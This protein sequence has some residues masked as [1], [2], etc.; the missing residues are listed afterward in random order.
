MSMKVTMAEFVGLEPCPFCGGE[1]EVIRN[2]IGVFVGCFHE[3]CPIGPATSTYVDGYSTEAEAIR[4][5][6]TR[7]YTEADNDAEALG[8]VAE[9]LFCDLMEADPVIAKVWLRSWP[10]LFEGVVGR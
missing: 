3:D 5:W 4:A 8:N 2:D 1:A 7:A 10:E 6:N 9:G